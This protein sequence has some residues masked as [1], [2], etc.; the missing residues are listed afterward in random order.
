MCLCRGTFS[1]LKVHI[2]T[3]TLHCIPASPFLLQQFAD[4]SPAS[5][6]PSS[7]HVC[8]CGPQ[9]PEALL[10]AKEV[11]SKQANGTIDQLTIEAE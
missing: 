10:L 5:L 6:C 4:T 3:H 1:E 9:K 2:G 7:A 11:N 8:G